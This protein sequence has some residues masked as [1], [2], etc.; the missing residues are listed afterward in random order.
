MSKKICEKSI[1]NILMYRQHKMIM[2]NREKMCKNIQNFENS[3]F[4]WVGYQ[5]KQIDIMGFDEWYNHTDG[6]FGPP[7]T[8]EQRKNPFCYT[9]DITMETEDS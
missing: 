1:F 3:T 2:Q 7:E 6:P 5:S 4:K 9:F 8:V